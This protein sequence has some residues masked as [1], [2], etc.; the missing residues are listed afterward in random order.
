MLKLL[1]PQ[2]KVQI[3]KYIP[4]CCQMND[5]IRLSKTISF[6]L[7]YFVNLLI[8]KILCLKNEK[9]LVDNKFTGC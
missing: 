9:F 1:L 5:V 8:F 4:V 7:L 6:E 3:L 2:N